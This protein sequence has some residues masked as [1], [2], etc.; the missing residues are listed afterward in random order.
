MCVSISFREVLKGLLKIISLKI[1]N[2]SEKMLRCNV[3]FT[4]KRGYLCFTKMVAARATILSFATGLSFG[5]AI[6]TVLNYFNKDE[7]IRKLFV[8]EKDLK[9]M[10][11][12]VTH[13]VINRDM[14]KFKIESK[15]DFDA[16]IKDH[17][18]HL[19]L[20]EEALKEKQEIRILCWVMTSPNTLHTKG[21]PVKETWGKR[22][23][24][25]LFMSSEEDPSFPAIGLD[26][27]EGR[28]E[29]WHKTRA[30]WDYVYQHHFDDADWFIKADDDT[31]VIIENLRHL[32]SS[33]DSEKPHYLGRHFKTFGGYNSGGAGYV[34]S[35]ETLRRFKKALGDTSLCS[36]DSFA[37]DVE[38]GKCLGAMGVKPAYTRDTGGRETFMPLPPEHHL[39][40]GYLSKDFNQI[41]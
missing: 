7:T 19:S 12:D 5:I 13:Q 17:H 8:P 29:L 21:K 32:V 41:N 31:F 15:V 22:C 9:A 38:V 35:K 24:K 16:D 27:S 25:L 2:V 26:V 1:M 34:F 10:S 36:K 14:N 40:P 3:Y 30:A 18:H 11:Q 4:L 39:I 37:E 33:L 28:D 6:I 20:N 23:N